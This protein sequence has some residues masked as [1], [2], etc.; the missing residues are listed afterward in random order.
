MSK[1]CATVRLTFAFRT[2]TFCQFNAPDAKVHVV[3]AQ[4]LHVEDAVETP[5]FLVVLV[6]PGGLAASPQARPRP[7]ELSAEQPFC[8]GIGGLR[9]FGF[10]HFYVQ[11]RVVRPS[12]Q[13]SP[14][15]PRCAVVINMILDFDGCQQRRR[16][17]RLRRGR[18]GAECCWMVLGLGWLR[19]ASLRAPS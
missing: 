14:R 4:E 11:A 5:A 9:R 2:F 16:R 10:R 13:P 18:P 1:I 19:A 15:S 7:F 17:G 8:S 3:V 6:R 12:P